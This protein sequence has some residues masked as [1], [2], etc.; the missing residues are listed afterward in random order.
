[1]SSN[2]TVVVLVL[3]RLNW[4]GSKGAATERR[5]IAFVGKVSIAD[6]MPV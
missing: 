3:G 5:G 6:A 1:M 2:Q 4:D